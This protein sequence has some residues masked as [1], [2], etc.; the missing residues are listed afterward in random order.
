MISNLDFKII[1]PSY[2]KLPSYNHPPNMSSLNF[3]SGSNIIINGSANK[4]L[5]NTKL[6]IDNDTLLLR[7]DENNFFGELTLME[8][9]KGIITCMDN[10]FNQESHPI[11]YNFNVDYDAY[12]TLSDIL[13]AGSRPEETSKSIICLSLSSS[14]FKNE[15]LKI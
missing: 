4:N 7:V 11:T 9:S 5:N 6:I 12:P 3:P 10:I 13:V 2:T 14:I 8:N 1:P 15:L